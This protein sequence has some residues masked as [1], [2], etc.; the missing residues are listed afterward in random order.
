MER[1]PNTTCKIC[2]KKYYHCKDCETFGS[3]RLV[4]CSAACYSEWLKQIEARD[5][6]NHAP[7]DSLEMKRT[8]KN[9]TLKG[10]A[11]KH[12]TAKS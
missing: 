11:V 10:K 4:A 9:S 5:D 8:G 7:A 6:Q 2:G 1:K 3:W 12:A